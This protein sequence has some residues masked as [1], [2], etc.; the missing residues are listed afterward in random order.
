MLVHQRVC[1]GPFI[2]VY[3]AESSSPTSARNSAPNS[4]GFSRS[5]K[6]M[7]VGDAKTCWDAASWTHLHWLYH[8]W[9]PSILLVVG[10]CWWHIHNSPWKYA[11]HLEIQISPLCSSESSI[12]FL[13]L[14]SFLR[15]LAASLGG[16]KYFRA[17][18]FFLAKTSCTKLCANVQGL[19]SL[20]PQQ[21]A[22]WLLQLHVFGHTSWKFECFS[23]NGIWCYLVGGFNFQPIPPTPPKK[24]T[25]NW[26]HHP[27]YK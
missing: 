11:L 8:L 26:D 9:L 7:E 15:P 21:G 5:N 24:T 13:A 27:S 3:L 17:S 6:Y 12:F 14:P 4:A 1:S 18:Q 20:I 19:S 2:I 23:V 16:S 10:V 25:L 22:Q